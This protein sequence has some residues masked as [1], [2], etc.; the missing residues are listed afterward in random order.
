M[1]TI[2]WS[3]NRRVPNYSK[4]MVWPGCLM[5]DEDLPDF[6]AFMMNQV[7]AKH[8]PVSIGCVT[9]ATDH[10]RRRNS[11]PEYADVHC[12]PNYDPNYDRNK[13]TRIDYVFLVHD[14]DAS[15]WSF[16]TTRLQ[17]GMRW[18]EDV[19]N[20]DPEMYPRDFCSAYPMM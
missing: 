15:N 5:T 7:G 13:E 6:E 19:K 14:E 1:A 9:T 12:D 10:E 3:P 2:V 11:D 18:L 4:A 17:Y 16:C 20:N 8:P